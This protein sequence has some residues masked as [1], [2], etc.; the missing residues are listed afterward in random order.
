[1][2]S[3]SKVGVVNVFDL[4]FEDWS[5]RDST[6]EEMAELLNH[7]GVT[8]A[9]ALHIKDKLLDV[10]SNHTE[11]AAHMLRKRWNNALENHVERSL[12]E[13]VEYRNLIALMPEHVPAAL[14]AYQGSFSQHDPKLADQAIRA[15][16][17]LLAEGQ[18]LFHGGYWPTNE[19]SF[20]TSRPFSTSFCPQVALRNAEW[21]GKAYD[22]GR[23]DLM[24][25]RV[26][27]PTTK[28]FV[29]RREGDHG[30]EKEVVF[31]NGARLS[32]VRETRIADATVTKADSRYQSQQKVV[33]AYVIEVE[34]S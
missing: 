25:V 34:V 2:G 28:A 10:V 20:V 33:P 4:P 1:M 13:S 29:Y 7:G 12:D 27:E 26:N 16:G 15:H 30:N 19:Q 31:A 21:K 18:V 8:L 23:V 17:V 3:G 14:D 6:T 24:V 11:A 9:E 32:R 5:I 22:A